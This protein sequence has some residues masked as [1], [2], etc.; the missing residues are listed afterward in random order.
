LPT[1]GFTFEVQQLAQEDFSWGLEVKALSWGV[2]VGADKLVEVPGGDGVE[3]V[4]RGKERRI[5]PMAFSM[6]PFCQGE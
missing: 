3:I 6:P 4:L 1:G 5:R 2:V